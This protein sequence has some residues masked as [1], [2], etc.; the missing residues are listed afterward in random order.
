MLGLEC[1]QH[2]GELYSIVCLDAS[3]IDRKLEGCPLIV[4]ILKHQLKIPDLTQVFGVLVVN[5]SERPEV[6]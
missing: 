4:D 6:D 1:Y 3:C 5:L 2:V